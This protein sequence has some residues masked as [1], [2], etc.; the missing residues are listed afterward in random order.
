MS[1]RVSVQ[2]IFDRRPKTEGPII[3]TVSVAGHPWAGLSPFLIGP[4]DLY[5]GHSSWNMENAWQYSKVY[6]IYAN[7]LEPSESYFSWAMKGWSQQKA[8]RYPMGRGAKPAYSWWDG[9]A[10][11][12]VEARKKIYV[13]LYAEAVQQTSAWREL[14]RL[15]KES[16]ELTLLDY[17][18][19]DHK[20]L[21]Y[22]L[23]EVLNNPKRKMGHAFV[24][25][26]LLTKDKAL[27]Q[28]ELRQ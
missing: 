12:Y 24:L 18:A 9:K 27:K 26:M 20:L 6:P 4:V 23:T 16:K 10:L 17:D 28:V 11:S 21:G 7:G 13:P 19:Y 5:G 2:F 1:C 15:Y 3:S 8:V 14:K 22:S 25:M